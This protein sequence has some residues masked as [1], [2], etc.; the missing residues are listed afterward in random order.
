MAEVSDGDPLRVE[1]ASAFYQR[2]EEQA[3]KDVKRLRALQ[4]DSGG[5]GFDL[6]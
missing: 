6:G 3:Q 2:F 4:Q 1:E 5:W